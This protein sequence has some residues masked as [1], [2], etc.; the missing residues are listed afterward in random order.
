MAQDR[1][2]AGEL[3]EAVREFLEREV[4]PTGEA[5]RQF[6]ARVSVNALAIVERELVLGAAADTREL[7][8]LRALLGQDGE[9]SELN[10]ALAAAI[11]AGRFDERDGRLMAHLKATT[12]D[13][14]AI[15]NPKYR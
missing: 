5:R 14:L 1:P 15:A 8:R 4:L 6:L 11:R 2:S 9:L 12:A 3:L 7:G 10:A 13:K